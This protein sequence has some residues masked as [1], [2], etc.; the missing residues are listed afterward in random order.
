MRYQGATDQSLPGYYLCRRKY[1]MKQSLY[2]FALSGLLV[3]GFATSSALAQDTTQ[4]QTAAAPQAQMQGHGRGH[5]PDPNKQ[6]AHMSKKLSLTADQ[7]SQIKPILTDR[8]QQ[9]Q[10]LWQDQSLSKS[11]RHATIK[12]IRDDAN[13]RIEAILNDQQKQQFEAMQAKMEARHG[14]HKSGSG[15]ASSA[16]APQQ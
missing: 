12:S 4:P 16:P 8:Q 5:A 11:D 14:M 10:G 15:D 7:Q 2:K 9:M 3:A 13:T 1:M 6:L